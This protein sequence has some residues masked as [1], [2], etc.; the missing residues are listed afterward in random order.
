M[1]LITPELERALKTVSEL[2]MR[3]ILNTLCD[4]DKHVN[5]ILSDL[6]LVDAGKYNTASDGKT[7]TS[8]VAGQK[9]QRYEICS[10]CEKEYEVELNDSSSCTYHPGEFSS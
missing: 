9:R 8:S 7:T 5:A 6:L 1:G 2:R 4:R 10:N 3:V